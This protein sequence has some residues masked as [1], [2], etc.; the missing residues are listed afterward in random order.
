L[1]KK[2]QLM[3]EVVL[4]S[5]TDPFEIDVVETIHP[6]HKVESDS[7]SDSVNGVYDNT[8]A[9]VLVE[10]KVLE[11][12]DASSSSSSES[13][14]ESSA[15]NIA[16]KVQPDHNVVVIPKDTKTPTEES[17]V[18]VIP[19]TKVVTMEE[20]SSIQTSNVKEKDEE[21][22]DKQED[23]EVIQEVYAAL[24]GMTDPVLIDDNDNNNNNEQLNDKETKKKTQETTTQ[25][26]ERNEKETYRQ[27]IEEEK[28]DDQVE[29]ESMVN[30]D[31]EEVD[32]HPISTQTPSR[33]PS[34]PI[35]TTSAYTPIPT[36]DITSNVDWYLIVLEQLGTF[37]LTVQTSTYSTHQ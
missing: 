20:P 35:P 17:E 19:E 23:E 29:E 24:S 11:V 9:V 6:N 27:E 16:S 5:A 31:P 34:I 1:E 18:A 32:N 25:C 37:Y 13:E 14:S 8:D 3:K 15:M 7:G 33:Q 30:Y 22:E 36:P 21:E 4:E 2:D 12:S 26:D 10:E 28:N